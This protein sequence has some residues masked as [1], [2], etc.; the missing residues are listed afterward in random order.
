LLKRPKSPSSDAGSLSLR[1]LA[2]LLLITW[3]AFSFGAVYPWA[4]WPLWIGCVV[5][6][7]TGL[8]ARQSARRNLSLA[9][10]VGLVLAAI[11][12]QLLPIPIPTLRPISPSTDE[13]LRQ[14]VLGY[15]ASVTAH[16]LSIAP[17]STALALSAASALGL[18]LLG[19]TR[20]LTANDARRIAVG[21]TSIGLVMA[22]VALAQKGLGITKIYGFWTPYQG[23]ES[24]FGPFVNRNHFAGWML[25]AVPLALGELCARIATGMRRVKPDW[26]SRFMWFAS[27]EANR[28]VFV[29][30][31]VLVMAIAL[32]FSLS[33]S[34]IAGLLLA[35]IVSGAF[36]I[37]GP[38]T[39][40]RRVLTAG[41]IGLLVFLAIGVAG[42]QLTARLG[43]RELLDVGGRIG[44][45]RD[46]WHIAQRFPLVGTGMDA[47]GTA[48]LFYQT[49]VG[50]HYIE[51][52]NDYL[53][54]LAEGGVLVSVPAAILLIAIVATIRRAFRGNDE[55]G[56]E[57]WIRMGAVTGLVGIALQELSDFSLQMPGNAV[58]FVTLLTIASRYPRASARRVDI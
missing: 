37:S 18:L 53:Q 9:A 57:Y 20:V 41:Y 36:V 32:V 21:V 47:Y 45:W 16:P 15:G 10:A 24:A 46:A 1:A 12:L 49:V 44:A 51:A 29:A 17:S 3:G 58:L 6:A 50:P 7:A 27:S 2:T 11:A 4:Y 34:G 56:G 13:L 55:Q 33:R 52:H 23:G 5:L 35:A 14:H 43:A 25:M 19:L 8:L 39:T 22:L 28:T 30:F 42:T 48:T 38:S 54:L 40:L 26:H 31:S